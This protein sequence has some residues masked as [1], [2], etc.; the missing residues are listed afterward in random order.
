MTKTL[1][2]KIVK[3]LEIMSDKMADNIA[4]QKLSNFLLRQRVTQ[5]EKALTK[6]D[7]K[8]NAILKLPNKISVKPWTA[9]QIKNAAEIKKLIKNMKSNKIN[10]KKTS[11]KQ[12]AK[13]VKNA[14]KLKSI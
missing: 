11:S 12:W 14:A 3:A 1:L 9:K 10:V 13:Q 8:L 4:E 6:T 7:K 5:L 2:T